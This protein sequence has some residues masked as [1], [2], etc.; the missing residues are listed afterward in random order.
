MKVITTAAMRELELKSAAEYNVPSKL[1][2]DHAGLGVARFV[3][4]LFRVKGYY[5]RVVRLVAGRGNNGGDVFAAA[6]HLRQMK[7]AVDLLLA[8][9]A[10]DISGD[11]LI[12]LNRLKSKR[13]RVN[14][15]P[16]LKDWEEAIAFVRHGGAADAPIVVDGVLG[17]GLQGP[18][19]GPASG[20]IR[21][22]N[23]QANSSLVVAVDVPSGLD[24]DTGLATGEAVRADYTLTM[25]LP[26]RG[27]V[28]PCAVDHVG[29]LEVIPI[30][31]PKELTD[32]IASDLELIAP[33]DLQPLFVRR[34]RGSHK[35]AFGHLLIVGGAAGY[36]GAA[37]LAA[38]AALRSGVGL[39]TVV[40]PRG[41][42]DIVGSYAPE[43]MVHGVPETEIGSLT[44]GWWP[45]WAE[46]RQAFSAILAGPGMTRH[47]ETATLVR[48]LLA[49]AEVPLALDA[50]AL[51][52]FEGQLAEL[53]QHSA[54]LVI[55]PHPGEMAR[56]LGNSAGDVQARRFE[57]ARQAAERARA[58]VVLKGA[59]TLVAE[60]GQP[61]SVNLGGNPGM[62]TG[63][64]GDVLAGLLGGLLAQG[65]PPRDAARA[66]VFL[67]GR[68]GDLA[69]IKKS[70]AGLI[71]GDL[72]EELPGAFQDVI[73]R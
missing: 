18:A 43:A 45:A 44:S 67:H 41:I 22:I 25:G 40:V 38:R 66:A 29:R 21:F 34:A 12:Y 65:L 73:P 9:S 13:I 60:A 42:V 69:A 14:E 56:L 32:N 35:G 71:A 48:L 46:R 33:S 59:G 50:D 10:Q 5:N 7:Y 11:A 15:L 62:A 61:L 57:A 6:W 39:V 64:V 1:L 16:T 19:R 24:S 68:A 30:G 37:A 4:Y 55:T 53:A 70:E 26:K 23:T 58:V 27:L 17:T 63:G 54:P 31:I 49:G 51:N 36:S 2:M 72:I 20:A 28:E 52:V 8:G 3:D 47:A